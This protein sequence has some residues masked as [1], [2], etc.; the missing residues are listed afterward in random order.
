MLTTGSIP[1]PRPKR[2]GP[3]SPTKPLPC[4]EIKLKA[5]PALLLLPFLLAAM[6]AAGTWLLDSRKYMLTAFVMLAETL[7]L[8]FVSFEKKRPGAREVALIAVLCALGVAGRSAFFML[9]QFKP[10]A[11]LAILCAAAFGPETGF[12]VG[13]GLMLASNLFFGQGAWTPW[14]MC[15]LGLVG[16]F[17]GIIF[18]KR[19]CRLTLCL[20]GGITV[21]GIY[22]LIMNLSSAVTYQPELSLKPILPY[23]VSGVPFDL[24]HAGGTVIFLWL[25][26]EPVLEKLHR[27]KTKFDLNM[28]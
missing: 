17:T 9:P 7:A 25:L 5:R 13:A 26:S 24:I 22:G 15:A 28:C 23:I 21:F 2:H 14:Q 6:L 19:A 8:F 12:I 11:A 20:W 3:G 27:V 4:S 18:R 1:P 16:Y 10:V